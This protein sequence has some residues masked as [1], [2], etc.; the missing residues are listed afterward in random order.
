MPNSAILYQDTPEHP[1]VLT[2]RHIDA[3][4][5]ENRSGK[6][7]W[8]RMEKNCWRTALTRRSCSA[9]EGI[10]RTRAAA[11]FRSHAYKSKSQLGMK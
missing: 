7:C 6:V 11:F 9:G 4:A 2:Q 8:Y 3:L 5:V 1:I 10:R